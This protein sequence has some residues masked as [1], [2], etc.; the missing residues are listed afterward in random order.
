MQR[1]GEKNAETESVTEEANKRINRQR[2]QGRARR[3]LGLAAGAALLVVGVVAVRRLLPRS[4]TLPAPPAILTPRTAPTPALPLPDPP[5]II[6]HSSDSPATVRGVPI[7]ADRLNRIHRH[8]HPNWATKFE[9][10]TYYI[11]YHY[12]ILPDGTVEQGRPD[13]CPGA[14]AR[15]YNNW[16]GICLIGAFSTQANPHW[17]PS[18]PTPAQIAALTIL[19]HRLMSAYHI[20][21]D[22]VKR[23]RDVNYTWCPG[24]RFP[25]DEVMQDLRAYAAAHPETLTT[26]GRLASIKAPR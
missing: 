9:G 22:R 6:L 26:D 13:H 16:I 3:L 14:H 24:G 8:D 1:P 20:P 18:T 17:W 19:C 23:H 15:R 11:G 12:V 21:P 2:F 7:N 10:K 4:T 25:Y 5:G